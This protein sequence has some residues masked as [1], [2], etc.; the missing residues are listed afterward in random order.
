MPTNPA[1]NRQ[2]YLTSL[3]D[4]ISRGPDYVFIDAAN[5]SLSKAGYLANRKALDLVSAFANREVYDALVYKYYG[6]NWENQLVNSYFV[7]KTLYPGLYEDVSLPD[8]SEEMWRLFFGGDLNY[9]D[10]T[11]MQK[12]SLSKVLD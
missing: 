7:G 9:E 4:L 5:L 1:G 2:P 11:G 6:T 12:T 8:K 3:E 10:V